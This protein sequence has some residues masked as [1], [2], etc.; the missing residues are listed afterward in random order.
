MSEIILNPEQRELLAGAVKEVVN[1]L[2]R[3]QGEKDFLGEVRK[4]VKEEL[5]L[6]PA[7]FNKLCRNAFEN[8]FNKLNQETTEILDLAEELNYYSHNGDSE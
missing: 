1:S 4:R 8:S 5:K 3:M 2:Y 6:P 7:K